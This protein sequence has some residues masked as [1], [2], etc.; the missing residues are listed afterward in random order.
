MDANPNVCVEIRLLPGR[1]LARNKARMCQGLSLLSDRHNQQRKSATAFHLL[2]NALTAKVLQ[3]N[4]CKSLSLSH[5]SNSGRR[6]WKKRAWGAG[7]KCQDKAPQ[8]DWQLAR[9]TSALLS[10]DLRMLHIWTRLARAHTR[11]WPQVHAAPLQGHTSTQQ[12]WGQFL[13][14]CCWALSSRS[15]RTLT[16]EGKQHM[17]LHAKVIVALAS[18][19]SC[20]KLKH[21]GL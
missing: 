16:A 4:K 11:A 5:H 1:A 3:T 14:C 10:K 7:M 20:P 9:A 21:P 19:L 17:L 15:S 12:Q 18:R 13:S 2:T 6:G 8:W